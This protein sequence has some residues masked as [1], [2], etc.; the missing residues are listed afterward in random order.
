MSV[1]GAERLAVQIAVSRAEAGDDS[2]LYVLGETGP[3]SETVPETVS[4][5][6]LGFARA[7]IRNPFSFAASLFRGHKLLAELI[8]ADGVDILQT[9]LP[10]ANFWGLLLRV[11]KGISAIPTIH[12]NREFDYGDAD[13][14]LRAR[15]RRAAYRQMMRRCPAVVT[16]SAQVRD[17]MRD[18]LGLNENETSAMAVI[19]N[20][21]PMPEQ[22]PMSERIKIRTRYGADDTVPLILAAGRHTEQKNFA[23]LI[24]AAGRLRDRGVVFRMVIAGEGELSGAHLE[25]VRTLELEGHVSLPGNLTDLGRVMQSADVFVLPSLWE[26][27]PLV[28]LEAM[29]SGCAVVGTNIDGIAE[30]LQNDE[31][32]LVVPCD[33]A[34]AMTGA[35]AQLI[36]RPEERR[37]LA[38]GAIAM[39][40]RDYSFARVNRNLDELYARVKRG[41]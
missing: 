37:R 2:H 17:S 33:D 11:T 4:V 36:A 10:G 40:E 27:L 32:G 6:H 35:I 23:C 9:H 26:G 21:V 13:H 1:G 20:G 7:S 31:T 28:L 25:K 41:R 39:V 15:C 3:L 12:N 5:H 18:Q 19:P 22:L 30:V 24:D 8:A 14:P 34:D 29:A 16:V 38:K